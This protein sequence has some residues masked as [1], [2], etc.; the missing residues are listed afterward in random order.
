MRG[1]WVTSIIG[2]VRLHQGAGSAA[3]RRRRSARRP[4]APPAPPPPSRAHRSRS[5][6]RRRVAPRRTAPSRT[7]RTGPRDG[8]S[9]SRGAGTTFSAVPVFP[10][11]GTGVARRRRPRR[12]PRGV[13]RG[14]HPVTHRRE[15]AGI[16]AGRARRRGSEAPQHDPRRALGAGLLDVRDE[17]RRDDLPAVREH[18]VERRHLQRR[19]EQ[20]LLADRRAGSSR[21]GSRR[22][23]SRSRTSSCATRGSA[24][25]R[26]PRRRCRDPSRRRNRTCAPTAACARDSRSRPRRSGCRCRRSTC[27]TTRR[28]PREASSGD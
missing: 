11:I 3:P 17:V 23:P 28:A 15:R 25:G 1:R 27:R 7:T 16:D 4:S 12:C 8:R 5:A 26:P 6:R 13:R 22:D 20:V 10:E 18:R 14:V 9:D 2:S 21:R 19:D 24:R